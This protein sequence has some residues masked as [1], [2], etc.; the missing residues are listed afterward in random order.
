MSTLLVRVVLCFCGF[1]YVGVSVAKFDINSCVAILGSDRGRIVS[2]AKSVARARGKEW[3]SIKVYDESRTSYAKVG[4]YAGHLSSLSVSEYTYVAG[5]KSDT[6]VATPADALA[7]RLHSIEELYQDQLMGVG[8]QSGSSGASSTASTPLVARQFSNSSSSSSAPLFPEIEGKEL[9]TLYVRQV[10]PGDTQRRESFHALRSK[11]DDREVASLCYH[12]QEPGD[13]SEVYQVC[14][15]FETMEATPDYYTLTKEDGVFRLGEKELADEANRNVLNFLEYIE[16]EAA[17]A[18]KAKVAAGKAGNVSMYNKGDEMG[19]YRFSA[20]GDEDE[21]EFIPATVIGTGTSIVVFRYGT[22]EDVA[23]GSVYQNLNTILPKLAF[24]RTY[25]TS[26]SDAEQFHHHQ[27]AQAKFLEK[28]GI[29]ILP[30]KFWRSAHNT[31][32]IAQPYLKSENLL[33]NYFDQINGGHFN[34][35]DEITVLG[36]KMKVSDFIEEVTGLIIDGVKKLNDLNKGFRLHNESGNYEQIIES[37]LDAKYPNY[38][39]FRENGGRLKLKYFD[40]FPAH[41]LIF[42][43]NPKD[44]NGHTQFEIFDRAFY[45]PEASDALV[46][47]GMVNGYKEKLGSYSELS[48]MFQKLAASSLDLV[49]Q[50]VPFHMACQELDSNISER[51][52]FV[53]R[54]IDQI[55]DVAASKF[56]KGKIT[57]EQALT[58]WKN[59]IRKNMLLRL[60]LHFLTY[61][62]L[63]TQNE[64]RETRQ[65]MS[66]SQDEK[67]LMKWAEQ[68]YKGS[69]QE[70]VAW[71][72]AGLLSPDELIPILRGMVKLYVN[73]EHLTAPTIT[74]DYAFEEGEEL[75]QISRPLRCP[76]PEDPT[77]R[78]LQGVEYVKTVAKEQ[79]KTLRMKLSQ[80]QE[81]EECFSEFHKIVRI[82][83]EKFYKTW[84]EP[85]PE[86]LLQDETDPYPP[87][88]QTFTRP[89]ALSLKFSGKVSAEHIRK[90]KGNKKMKMVLEQ[91]TRVLRSR[92][93]RTRNLPPP[94]HL[95]ALPRVS[96]VK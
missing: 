82:Q 59:R 25:F 75:F 44:S 48:T 43:R 24:R 14:C 40:L 1:L 23:D 69:L 90:E 51:S 74:P 12:F 89:L 96:T 46:K 20:T 19:P 49:Y 88:S 38:A 15:G 39:I 85:A 41:L 45:R 7:G 27:I 64:D 26:C 11:V 3:I 36:G 86:E 6:P 66:A 35:D 95:H 60:A 22:F 28:N 94:I 10:G 93:A 92:V 58:Y 29:D 61:T 8:F 57:P 81:R 65:I 72:K 71:A 17:D 56:L 76:R 80:G 73:G 30:V 70:Y 9:G 91:S 34:V 47:K 53:R 5:R 77:S 84:K 31:V 16:G 18:L 63:L 33:E 52:Q 83:L 68:E 79:I 50:D 54:I 87:L 37:F 32:L 2:E 78:E 13:Q 21:N 42:G 62:E 67:N 4:E 55:N